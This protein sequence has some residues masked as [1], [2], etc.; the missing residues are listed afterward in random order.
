MLSRHIFEMYQRRRTIDIF[1]EICLKHFKD[2]TW[3]TYFS[4]IETSWRR[5]KKDIS[6]E[7]FL[8]HHKDVTKKTS[9]QSCFWEVFEMFL[10]IVIWLRSLKD[11]S[12]WLRCCCSFTFSFF[13]RICLDIDS[14]QCL[15]LSFF[16]NHYSISGS[17]ASYLSRA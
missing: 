8:T 6:F 9:L 4:Q 5:Q 1:L 7:I 10:S 12:C 16:C 14:Q 2:A 13:L 3:K 11:I 17:C 15:F